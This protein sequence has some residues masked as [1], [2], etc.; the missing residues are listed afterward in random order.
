MGAKISK[1]LVRPL[2]CKALTLVEVD[3]GESRELN[4]LD[5]QRKRD[6]RLFRSNLFESRR[7]MQ[8]ACCSLVMIT[9]GR[10][11]RESD[12][13]LISPTVLAA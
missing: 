8:R 11:R 2:L 13:G 7:M 1:V 3:F 9:V 12:G 6:K 4:P 10:L 5:Q